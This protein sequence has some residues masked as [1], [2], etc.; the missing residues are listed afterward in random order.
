MSLSSWDVD[1]TMVPASVLSS[2]HLLAQN[3]V[4]HGGRFCGSVTGELR[5]GVRQSHPYNLCR[6]CAPLL[7]VNI[8][9][10]HVGG[11]SRV[12][13]GQFM[14]CTQCGDVDLA[15]GQLY[16]RVVRAGDWYLVREG[17]TRK[18]S[19]TFYTRPQLASPITRRALQPLLYDG[20]V[21]R[22]PG[23]TNRQLL[24]WFLPTD[25]RPP[26]FP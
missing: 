18:G 25:L 4:Q 20:D 16:T 13:K 11:S 24:N 2:V 5:S 21:P 19:G 15:A 17:A 14:F 1:W 10:E 26:N 6:A 9:E 22:T 12:S 23:D 7:L 8:G 3:F